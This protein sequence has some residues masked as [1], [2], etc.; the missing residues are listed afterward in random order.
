MEATRLGRRTPQQGGDI[1]APFFSRTDQRIQG[2]S[3]PERPDVIGFSFHEINKDA[4]VAER[5][6][7][8]FG[9]WNGKIYE[10][11]S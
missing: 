2:P 10:I 11:F 1:I 3:V 9:F 6:G 4:I 7:E 5:V 8:N